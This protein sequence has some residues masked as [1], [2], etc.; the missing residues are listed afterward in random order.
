MSNTIG[1]PE[2]DAKQAVERQFSPVAARYSTS[3]VHARGEDLALMPQIAE[4]TG[5]EEVLDAGCGPG[6]TALAFAPRVARVVALDLSDAMLAEGRRLAQ[7][8]SIANLEFRRGDVE[9]LPFADASFDLVVSRYSAHH[10]P[11]PQRALAEFR[12]VLRPGGAVVLSDIIAW[13][14][15]AADSYLQAIELLRDPSHVRDHTAAQWLGCLAQAGFG[16]QVALR[17][18]V[19]LD[20]ASWLARAATPADQAKAIVRLIDAAP[21]EVHAALRVE[22]DHSFTLQGAVIKG[23]S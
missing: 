18:A 8:R 3:A 7:E 6:H 22:P 11:H 16:A 10:W 1:A 20:F 5:S 9:Y 13:D 21:Q 12:R 14:G 2:R 17:F 19:R 23:T 4:V 15:P